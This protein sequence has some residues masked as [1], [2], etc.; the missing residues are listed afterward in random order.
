MYICFMISVYCAF[1]KQ[2]QVNANCFNSNSL[3][4]NYFTLPLY[5][6]FVRAIYC[7]VVSQIHIT[8]G[9]LCSNSLLFSIFLMLYNYRLQ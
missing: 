1:V 3:L 7:A 4:F 8:V 5:C 6:S 9:W 2:T